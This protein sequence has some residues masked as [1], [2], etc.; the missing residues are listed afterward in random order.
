M[1]RHP[2]R[3]RGFVAQLISIGLLFLGLLTDPLMAAQLQLRHANVGVSQ[4]SVLVGDLIDVEMWVDSEGSEISGAAIFL[5]FDEDVFDIVEEDQEPGIAGF[6][7]F[8]QGNFLA[9][10]EVFRNAWLE[11]GDPAA[12][13]L[14]EQ[15]DYS[16]VRASDRGIGR[17]ATFRLRAKAPAMA[18]DVQI[19]ETGLRETRV[20]LPDGSSDAFRFIT[21]LSIIV[22]GIG[23]E[24][25]PQELVLA[26]GQVD[27]T[28]FRLADALFDPLYGPSDIV[29]QVSGGSSLGLEI[30]AETSILT[31]RAP[32]DISPWERLTIAATNPDGQ[33]SSTVVDIF[34]NAGPTLTAP[35]PLITVEDVA[36][37]LDLTAYLQDPDTPA[38]RLSWEI[39]APQTVLVEISGP[40]WLA[41]ITPI[42]DWHGTALI[43]LTVLDQYRYSDTTDLELSVTP[44]NDPPTALLSPNLQ[45]T[46]GKQDSTLHLANIFR[47]AEQDAEF[48]SVSWSGNERIQIEQRGDVM[49][50]TAPATWLGSE[51]IQLEASDAEGEI[52]TS[53]LTVTIVPSLAPE[54][55]NPPGRL[56]LVSGQQSVIDLANFA[57]DPDDPLDDLT[58][59]WQTEIGSEL[60]V[61]MSASGA[62]LITAPDSFEGLE[63]LRFIVADPS[64]E[65]SNFDLLVFSA[66]V[67]GAPLLIALPTIELPAGGVDASIDLDAFVLDLNHD[68]EQMSWRATGV[69]GLEVRVDEVSHVLSISASDSISGDF[70]IGLEATDPT[71][72][73]TASLVQVAVL[74]IDGGNPPDNP[75]PPDVP[76]IQLAS[77]PTLAIEAGAFNQSLDLGDYLQG[78]TYQNLAWELSGGQHT[79]AYV[80]AA[81]GRVVVLAD[82]DATG[83]EIL[84]IRGL[85]SFGNIVVEGLIGVQIALVAPS[86][87]LVELSE[88]VTLIGD[89]LLA[90]TPSQLLVSVGMDESTLQW[91]ASAAI[92]VS[93]EIDAQTGDLNISGDILAVTGSHLITLQATASDGSVAETRLLLQVLPD[94]GSAGVE[95]D[96]FD[97]AIVP[98][99]IQPDFL[100]LYLIDSLSSMSTPRLRSRIDE[101]IEVEVEDLGN[102]IWNGSHV[103]T[104]GMEGTIEF[105]ALALQDQTLY[106]DS[107]S[108]HVGTTQAG[109]GRIVAGGGAQLHVTPGSFGDETL[110]VLIPS[111]VGATSELTP[112]SAG[113]EVHATR[114]LL[115]PTVLE[116]TTIGLAGDLYRFDGTSKSWVFMG[117]ERLSN[118]VTRS[119]AILGR[120]ALFADHVAPTIVAA[121]D[122]RRLQLTDAG[123]GMDVVTFWVD[124]TPLLADFD[125]DGQWLTLS[126]NVTGIVTMRASDRAGNIA[127]RVLDFGGSLPDDFDLAQNYPNPFNPE[128]TIPLTLTRPGVVRVEVIDLL[129]QRIRLL[130]DD[131]LAAGRHALRWFGANDLGQPAASGIYFY[132]ATTTEGVQTRRMTL[133]R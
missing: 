33:V 114:E 51:L 57:S 6:Q 12:S 72:R 40:P 28:T 91:T 55:L 105:L 20:F 21:P 63:T 66:P 112:V 22:R 123:S 53:L 30:D 109:A 128:T 115:S 17:V 56:G 60:L 80:D 131:E 120:Y 81:T 3:P 8:A 37:E 73:S 107:L 1:A 117:G 32:S 77:F 79:Q 75:D 47:D 45:L 108:I 65:Q 98:N 44:L 62:A 27:S 94:D 9:N 19:D 83:A 71:G 86:L 34:V 93:L 76:T 54:F 42:E 18:T 82:T 84:S 90:L 129:G 10:G 58:W 124:E 64:G 23:I 95:R 99:P 106:K 25:L 133:L 89:A 36:Y 69:P 52:A 113:V 111:A 68:P 96:G 70:Q 102:G 101:W 125:F 29:W 38:S 2:R 61:Q 24:G 85:D 16:I 50:V 5:T 118:S 110:V 39:D 46:R 88:S 43:G 100:N 78:A 126:P 11:P 104:L 92:G 121:G 15:I 67:D 31:V 14:G 97:L 35:A 48:L 132:R 59:S 103:I 127:E 7:P 122:Q 87:E 26:R 116:L 74:G 4:T 130:I 49:I 13:P 119:I 41:T